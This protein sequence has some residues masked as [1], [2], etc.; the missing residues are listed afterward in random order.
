MT[1]SAGEHAGS[2][3][4]SGGGQGGPDAAV[5]LRAR[6]PD[7]R[8]AAELARLAG[9]GERYAGCD[10]AVVVIA[11]GR[12][13][14]LISALEAAR[15]AALREI[16][17]RNPAAGHE[18]KPGAPGDLPRLWLDDTGIQVGL[19]LARTPGSV[20]PMIELAVDLARLPLIDQQLRAG[21]LDYSRTKLIAGLTAGLSDELAAEAEARLL[22]GDWL[23]GKTWSQ[24]LRRLSRI[25]INLDPELARRQR[26]AAEE[27]A[28]VLYG[29]EG[30]GTARLAG[31]NLPADEALQA[32]ACVSARALAYRAYGLPG[33]IE[34]LR[35]QAFLDIL[36]GLDRRTTSSPPGTG[37]GTGTGSAPGAGSGSEAGQ[38]PDG[39]DGNRDAD[40]SP[41]EADPGDDGDGGTGGDRDDGDG[42]PGDDGD[43]GTGNDGSGGRGG[44]GGLAAN[45]EL[46][47]PLAT[48]LGIAERAGEADR[49]G[50]IDPALARSLAA[51]A[52]A[53]PASTF[54]IVITDENG[55]A[56]GFGIARRR[57]GQQKQRRP[58]RDTPP[59]PAQQ[60]P[61]ATRG[62][63]PMAEFTPAGS[64]QQVLPGLSATGL[65]GSGAAGYGTWRIRIGDLELIAD[66][67][68]IPRD[69]CGHELA[70][71]AY[72]PTALLRALVQ[73][74]DGSCSLPICPRHPRS[75]EWEHGIPWPA[76]A[77]CGCNG[78]LHCKR[79][80]LLKQGPRW[81]IRQQPDGRRT[82]TSPAGLDYTS[83]LHDY[84]D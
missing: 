49:I 82:W 19:E 80:H 57:P 9:P 35:A 50:A 21:V 63:T 79:D 81:A 30:D 5:A 23:A 36:A 68:R 43:G 20:A 29:T 55:Y 32:D 84:P 11:A 58:G 70:T 56:A 26:E 69:G 12:Y 17:R 1:D 46:T 60:G 18:A 3:G 33:S 45:V 72:R 74:R 28:R 31:Y 8:L 65:N 16:V 10:D 42:G 15:F 67:H 13:T 41:G 54:R 62:S 48:L 38:G 34:L 39:E 52:A 76:G 59:P 27:H 2:G 51:R 37:T 64:G 53:S 75:C 44:G 24:I 47:I 78:G 66:L 14:A 7:L 83:H 73:V 6:R 77:T 4:D 71:T 22:A 25:V 40:P 61:P